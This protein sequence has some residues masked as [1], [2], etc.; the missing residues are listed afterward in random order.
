MHLE[1]QTK[2]LQHFDGG[3]IRT[4]PKLT[5]KVPG[6]S[7]TTSGIALYMPNSV[8]VSYN[9]SYDTDTEAGLAGDFEATGVAV[10]GV[11]AQAAK[12]EAALQ[13][14]VGSTLEMQ[15]QF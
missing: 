12:V 7:I 3:T 13:G 2:L 11:K 1:H 6:H 5:A 15:K 9:Q 14:V 8:K 10:A 4:T